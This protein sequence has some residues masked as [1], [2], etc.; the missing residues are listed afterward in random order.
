MNR[1]R[2][3]RGQA[4]G[5]SVIGFGAGIVAGLLTGQWV[6]RVTRARVGIDI[7]GRDFAGDCGASRLVRA[8]AEA[9]DADELLHAHSLKAS[10]VSGR[11]VEVSG[12]VPN[13][14]TRTRAMRLVQ[15]LPDIESV[16]NSILVHGEDDLV[17]PP[18]ASP[19]SQSA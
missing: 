1:A 4:L 18:D 10:L 5:W 14:A 8:A 11:T 17:A 7:L 16:I 13:R 19:A 6:G 15:A 2:L 12:W 9:L 3:T